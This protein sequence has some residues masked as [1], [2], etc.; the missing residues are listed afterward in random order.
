MRLSTKIGAA[1]VTAAGVYFIYTKM[2]NA[3]RRKLAGWA[4]KMQKE[5]FSKASLMRIVDPKVFDKV[6]DDTARAYSRIKDVGAKELKR[7]SVELKKAFTEELTK[8]WRDIGQGLHVG[9]GHSGNGAVKHTP[10]K[11][12]LSH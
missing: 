7:V 5:V 11:K 9:N 2:G 12:K 1:S 6:V 3:N 8:T 10:H 4:L